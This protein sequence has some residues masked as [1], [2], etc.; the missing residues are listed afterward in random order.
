MTFIHVTVVVVYSRKL[1]DMRCGLIPYI[2]P[3]IKTT[4]R[5]AVL[6]LTYFPRWRPRRGKPT[7][8][9]SSPPPPARG[10]K[11]QRLAISIDPTSCWL[12]GTPYIQ[13]KTCTATKLRWSMITRTKKKR[14]KKKKF[15]LKC[16]Q[17]RKQQLVRSKKT[18]HI[19]SR[20]S[21]FRNASKGDN[22]EID[23]SSLRHSE[24][25][26]NEQETLRRV[27]E[28]GVICCFFLFSPIH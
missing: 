21:S 7:I 10:E 1:I 9:G 3:K 8:V 12:D 24:D 25:E 11:R 26:N 16:N 5:E 6:S 17:W 23:S 18:D 20:G 4:K 22:R 14:K 15:K 27:D 2:L 19:S 28:S 13:G